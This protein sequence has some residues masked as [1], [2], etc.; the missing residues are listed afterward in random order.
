M[1]EKSSL[2]MPYDIETQSIS[3]K[4]QI[5]NMCLI[6]CQTPTPHSTNADCGK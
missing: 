1:G 2:I 3:G 4:C 5:S 6:P